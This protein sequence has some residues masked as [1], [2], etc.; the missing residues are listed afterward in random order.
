MVRVSALFSGGRGLAWGLA[1]DCRGGAIGFDAV[2]FGL[3][4]VAAEGGEE[5]V[6]EVAPADGVAQPD[7]PGEDIVF[8]E[9][10]CEPAL[11]ES[12]FA[13]R[14]RAVGVEIRQSELQS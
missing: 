4:H 11:G 9:V 2:D 3:G 7:G 5:V 10:A 8:G 13:N 12:L 1:G 6:E 14:P